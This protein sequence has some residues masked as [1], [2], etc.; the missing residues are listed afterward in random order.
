MPLDLGQAE[1]L[2]SA[3]LAHELT[4]E[5]LFERSWAQTLLNKVLSAL[6]QEYARRN[7]QTLFSQLQSFLVTQGDIGPVQKHAA[8]LGMSE[9]AVRVAVHRLRQRYRRL[10]E[11]MVADTV[12]AREDVADE[13]RHLAKVFGRRT[14]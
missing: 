1:P 9:G 10:L 2:F 11:D 14:A 8:A 4:P 3:E 7:Q 12:P 13:L 5:V 6:E